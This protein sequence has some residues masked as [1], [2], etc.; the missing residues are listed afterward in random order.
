MLGLKFCR[1]TPTPT[2][3]NGFLPPGAAVTRRATFEICR[4]VIAKQHL[5]C[6]TPHRFPLLLNQYQDIRPRQFSRNTMCH[7]FRPS[8]SLLWPSRLT[9]PRLLLPSFSNSAFIKSSIRVCS[10]PKPITWRSH[11]TAHEPYTM[12]LQPLDPSC[13]RQ[14]IRRGFI[15]SLPVLIIY[16]LLY[17]LDLGLHRTELGRRHLDTVAR[18]WTYKRHEG[19]QNVASLCTFVTS[20]F[21]HGSLA[22]LVMDSLVLVGI[23]SLLGSVFNRRTFFAVYILGGFLAAVA[24]C[25]WARV[26]NPCQS[27]TQAQHD[28]LS[29]SARIFN[30]A[31]AKSIELISSSQLIT[32]KGFVE[33]L[34]NPKEFNKKWV[35]DPGQKELK[36]QLAIVGKQFPILRDWVRWTE[37]NWASSGSLICL[38]MLPAHKAFPPMQIE[39]TQMLMLS[40]T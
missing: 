34:T 33:K 12:F 16:L 3:S 5:S 19:L 10:M 11:A 26:T 4:P 37:L 35:K 21:T 9:H 27:L 28:E 39:F 30:E 25:A 14:S 15:I 22:S 36:R 31:A 24:D 6:L 38:S 18:F 23:A 32:W 7:W 20:Q 1:S 2:I 40:E 17:L 8:Q 29:M 13:R